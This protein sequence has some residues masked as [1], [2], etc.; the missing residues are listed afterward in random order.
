MNRIVIP[1]VSRR[2]PICNYESTRATWSSAC[3][4][5]FALLLVVFVTRVT[6]LPAQDTVRTSR[7]SIA[8]RLERAEEAIAL[9][10]QQLGDQSGVQTRSRMTMELNGR[11]LM[12]AFSNTRR[13][14]NA[15]VPTFVRPDTNTGF[16]LGGAGMAIRQT[17]LGF[18]VSAPDLLG[19]AFDGGLDVDF[20]GGQQPSSGGRTFPLVRMRV[21]R[22]TLKWPNAELMVGQE[23]PLMSP[24]NPVSLASIG[25]PGFTSAGNL[26]LWLPQARLTLETSGNTRVGIAGAVLA[27]TSGEAAGLFDTDFDLA[28]RSRRP[29]VEGRA[30][31]GWG[32]DAMA[33]AIGVSAH[34]GWFVRPNSSNQREGFAFA[35]DGKI[36][37]SSH[38]ELRGEWYTGDGMRGLG[39]GAVGQLFDT[40]GEPVHST[41]YWGQVNITLTQRVTLGGGFGIDDPDND[42]LGTGGRLKNTT[43]EVHLNLRPAGPLVLGVEYRQMKTTYAFGPL[44]NDHLNI[45]V[46]F[47][48]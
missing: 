1:Q 39:G 48:F 44:T 47:A 40:N 24:L 12:H 38:V 23:S 30:H 4:R 28:E 17:T 11:V 20:F 46:G 27:P 3:G 26:W 21:A 33:G 5:L 35:A 6:P 8:A 45:A 29:F 32:S 10:R 37:L 9:L 18:A 15:D 43:T 13:V 36:P 19:A 41:G 22:A 16:P 31:L 25:I 2:T 42:F 7:D 34:G 14:N